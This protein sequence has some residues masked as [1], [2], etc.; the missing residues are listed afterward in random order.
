MPIRPA[1]TRLLA[2]LLMLQW[3]TA[4]AACLHLAAPA[5]GVTIEICTAEGIR[6]VT[7]PAEEPG[8]D[9]DRMAGAPSCPACLGPAAATLPAPVVALA[10]PV[11]LA[12]SADPPPAPPPAPRPAPSPSCQPRAPPSV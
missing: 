8:Q 11:I 3:G 10:A 2:L 12:Q 5:D 7:L 9:D 1:L 4:F 6:H